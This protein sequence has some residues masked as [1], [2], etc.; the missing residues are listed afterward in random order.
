M[1][2]SNNTELILLPS[3]SRYKLKEDFIYGDIKVP[4]GFET[5]GISY[6]FRLI[7]IFISKFDPMY[8][9]AVVVHDYL[10]DLGRWEEANTYFE[11]MLPQTTTAQVMID[12]VG[13]YKLLKG[14]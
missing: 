7:G 14:Y 8:I 10:T 3:G 1:K 5:D 11:E 4:A 6:K 2:H 9:E 12:A 13:F